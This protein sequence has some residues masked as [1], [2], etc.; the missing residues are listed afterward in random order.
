MSEKNKIK[1][2]RP[3]NR[4]NANQT[5]ADDPPVKRAHNKHAFFMPSL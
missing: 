5:N 3:E 4:F 1:N 2:K